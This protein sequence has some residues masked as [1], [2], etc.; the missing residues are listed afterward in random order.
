MN[1]KKRKHKI[2]HCSDSSDYSPDQLGK[3]CYL[4]QHGPFDK[5]TLTKYTDS[6]FMQALIG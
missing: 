3:K 4:L 6:A 5:N 1:T 2:K